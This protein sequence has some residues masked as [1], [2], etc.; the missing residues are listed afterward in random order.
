MRQK[1][2]GD[3][4][5]NIFLFCGNHTGS[6]WVLASWSFFLHCDIHVTLDCWKLRTFAENGEDILGL[7]AVYS[8]HFGDKFF[9]GLFPM[10]FDS[11]DSP[12]II[13]CPAWPPDL[14]VIDMPVRRL[15][16]MSSHP[17][18][19]AAHFKIRGSFG[20]A[21]KTANSPHLSLQ[22]PSAV[23]NLIT[24]LFKKIVQKTINLHG[25]NF[26]NHK[27]NPQNINLDLQ[28][29]PQTILILCN[30]N[31]QWDILKAFSF[32][33]LLIFRIF[34]CNVSN[35]IQLLQCLHGQLPSKAA[36]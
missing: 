23:I 27:R 4:G 24:V 30:S 14:L 15:L 10:F 12:F 8:C 11:R 3:T 5:E 32:Y 22:S 29:R 7:S 16:L 19:H 26:S 18:T 31:T 33:P 13:W 1:Y 25:N 9:L 34:I 20:Q 35:P 21:L 28:L 6:V 36:P 17:L 2:G